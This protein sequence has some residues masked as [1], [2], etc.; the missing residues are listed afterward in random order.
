MA[1]DVVFQATAA[2]PPSGTRVSTEEIT[3]LNAGAVTAQHAQRIIVAIRLSDG[4]AIDL[5]G[6]LADG[7]LVNLGS[8]NDVTVTGTITA[9][10]GTIGSA[11]TA[12]KQDTEIASLASL[13]TQTDG[14]EASLTSILAKIIAAPATEAKQDTANTSLASIDA[15]TPAALGQ[16][17]MADSQPVVIASNQTAVPVSL[18]STTITGAVDTELPAA[19]ALADNTANPTAP[20]VASFLLVWDGV[21]WDRLPGTAADGALMNLGA[22]NDVTVTSGTVTAN[23]GTIGGVAT[24]AKQDTANTSL[25]SLVTQT[26]GVEASL[27]SILAK[28]IAA[29]AT[30][31]K[32]DTGNTSLASI[33]A[34]IIAA[35]ATEAKQDTG[36]TSLAS[37]VTQTDGIEASL[38][39]IL[40]KIIAAPATEAKQDTGNTSLASLVTQTDAIEAS[41][42]SIDTGTPAALGQAVMASSQPVVIASDQTAIPVTLVLSGSLTDRSGTLTTGGTAQTLASAN[43][44]RKYLLVQNQSNGAFYIRFTGTATQDQTSLRLDAGADFESGPSFVPTQAISIIG[45]TTGQAWHAVEG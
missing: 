13:V 28:I 38:A 2:T 6:T 10:L 3:T 32:Q 40:A 17:V 34:K 30:E 21:T 8:N 9:N 43:S 22:N 16:A 41:L 45:A 35:P 19:A 20:A 5:P 1:D 39:S 7:V 23:L 29:P 44:S 12:A 33:L 11:A 37:L 42:S 26:D 25:A 36:N 24:E 15:G 14:I 4:T 18:T 31:A 27:V